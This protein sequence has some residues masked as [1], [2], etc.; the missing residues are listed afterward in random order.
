MK[1]LTAYI[2]AFSLFTIVHIHFT[3]VQLEKLTNKKTQ[4]E[5]V[6]N[7]RAEQLM[8]DTIKIDVNEK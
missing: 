2:I 1:L 3:N 5:L 8:N 4:L 7:Q 6:S